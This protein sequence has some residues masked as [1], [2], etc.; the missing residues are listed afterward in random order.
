MT[1]SFQTHTLWLKFFPWKNYTNW[2]K[3]V[4]AQ[5]NTISIVVEMGG[6]IVLSWHPM[7][8]ILQYSII[9]IF[10]IVELA[11]HFPPCHA[12]PR[13]WW[14]PW[15]HQTYEV[16]GHRKYRSGRLA[17]PICVL[18]GVHHNCLACRKIPN[19]KFRVLIFFYFLCFVNISTKGTKNENNISCFC[20]VGRVWP[21][22]TTSC[23]FPKSPPSSEWNLW[24]S[25]NWWVVTT[26]K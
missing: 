2:Q 25:P 17:K 22:Y 8:A 14:V 12:I 16:Y 1:I 26:W 13:S 7:L 10:R 5:F 18:E 4:W 11:H 24:L 21:N 9:L 3:L 20:I 6:Q 23:R 19:F 15:L